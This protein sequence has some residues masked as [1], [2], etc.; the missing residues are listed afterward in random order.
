MDKK[1]N[2]CTFC[3]RV[4]CS[5]IAYTLHYKIAHKNEVSEFP[6]EEGIESMESWLSGTS[7]VLLVSGTTVTRDPD[8]N[9]DDKTPE[10]TFKTENFALDETI[11]DE[12]KPTESDT[13]I[14]T[15]IEK[16]NIETNIQVNIPTSVTESDSKSDCNVSQ[17]NESDAKK[18]SE[19]NEC[20]TKSGSNGS[21]ENESDP[22]LDLLNNNPPDVKAVT[23]SSLKRQYLQSVMR[24]GYNKRGEKLTLECEECNRWYARKKNLRSHIRQVHKKE[25]V[26]I[27]P[28]CKFKV[29]LAVTLRNHITAVH[30]KEKP[31]KCHHCNNA[32]GYKYALKEHM[33]KHN[34][35]RDPIICEFC[36]KI[37][38]HDRYRIIHIKAVHQKLD[39][40][41]CDF[42]LKSF[43]SQDYAR[44]HEISVH[45]KI[46]DFLCDLC[47]KNFTLSS[48]LQTHVKTAHMPIE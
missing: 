42:C 11:E 3:A 9:F 34:S 27:C 30:E 47:G 6:N 38:S 15:Q 5:K 10:K 21:E 26:H 45:K 18:S 36:R 12:F 25:R 44:S 4:F 20:A 29:V 16:N 1:E 28:I 37:F 19:E 40:Y 7:T 32:Y 35:K 33:L 48:Y 14:Q 22:K 17:E 39:R 24:P 23:S 31:F 46:K 41:K 8:K 2:V 13:V 43:C